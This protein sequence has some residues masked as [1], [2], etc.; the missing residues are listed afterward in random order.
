MVNQRT[1]IGIITEFNPFHAGHRYLVENIRAIWP[2]CVIIA[3]MSGDFVQRGEPAIF[4]KYERTGEALQNGVDMVLQIPVMF[5]TA[6]AADFAAAGVSVLKATGIVDY[7]VFGSECGDLKRMERI[8]TLE[9]PESPERERFDTIVRESLSEGKSYAKA[10]A[11]AIRALT[12]DAEDLSPNDILGVSYIRAI[13]EQG[14]PFSYRCIVRNRAFPSAHSIRDALKAGC[15]GSD[16]AVSYA[17]LDMYSEM[18][19]YALFY[20]RYRGEGFMDYMDVSRELNDAILREM[21]R[22][23]RFRE[24]IE[25]LKSRNYTYSRIARAFLHILLDIKT[26]EVLEIREKVLSKD[27]KMPYLRILGVREDAKSLLGRMQSVVVTS[28]ARFLRDTERTDV[29]ETLFQKDLYAA[30]LYGQIYPA[31]ANEYTQKLITV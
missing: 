20:H 12:G 30:D 23:E 25:H 24:R 18:L 2:D 31:E 15:D 7:L 4:S 9:V 14:H 11:E 10:R 21:G 29:A 5:S 26:E 8:A 1:V 17:D 6:S 16:G 28:P 19:S 27:G 13:L 22:R 3:A